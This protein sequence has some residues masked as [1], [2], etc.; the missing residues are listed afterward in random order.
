MVDNP[1]D[2]GVFVVSVAWTIRG[3]LLMQRVEVILSPSEPEAI[4]IIEESFTLAVNS[5]DDVIPD[6]VSFTIESLDNILDRIDKGDMNY[7][8]QPTREISVCK[9]LGN[10][11]AN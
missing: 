3:Q 7:A 6:K 10:T 4:A 5:K 8:H 1:E 11:G 2:I 9:L